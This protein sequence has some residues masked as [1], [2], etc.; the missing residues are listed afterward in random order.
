MFKAP[1]SF[2]GRIRRKEYGFSII[3]YL[4]IAILNNLYIAH[5]SPLLFLII[6]IPM[7]WFIWAQGAKR[8]HDLGKNGFGNSFLSM[9]CGCCS[10]LGNMDLTSMG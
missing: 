7:V 5:I 8:C 9:D 2:K 4:A 1:F 3:I 6:L 10:N